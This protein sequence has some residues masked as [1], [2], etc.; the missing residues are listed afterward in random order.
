MVVDEMA[1]SR[2]K[3]WL[4]LTVSLGGLIVVAAALVWNYSAVRT[5]VKWLVWS[6]G[7]KSQ[8]LSQP[9]S[10]T[11]ELKHIEWDGWGMAGQ[12]TTV[13]LVFD[14]TDSL[15]AAAKSHRSGKFSGIPCEVFRVHR[16]E[17]Q[18]YTA[19]FYTNDYWDYCN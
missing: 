17:S 18:W 7:Y 11:G 1:A 8:V 5:T 15:S 4:A 12:D 13:F 9:V 19:Q 6:R 14:P 2:S 3:R 16:L 10:A